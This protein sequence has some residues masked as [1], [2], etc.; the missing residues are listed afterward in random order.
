MK[1]TITPIQCVEN[2]RW[3]VEACLDIEDILNDK[4]LVKYFIGE[5]TED[6]VNMQFGEVQ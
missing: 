5:I 4:K 1:L 2:G 6:T 3:F